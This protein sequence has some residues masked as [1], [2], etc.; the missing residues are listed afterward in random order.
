MVKRLW[1]GSLP[2]AALTVAVM[3]FDKITTDFSFLK[4]AVGSAVL[5]TAVGLLI[6][7]LLQGVGRERCLQHEEKFKHWQGP[8]TVASSVLLGVLV[9]L[10]SV[11]VG[12]LGV[13]MLTYLYPLRLNPSRMIASD[14]VHAIPLA[15]F[16]GIGHLLVGHVDF[17]LLAWLLFGS[18][19]DVW[20]GAKLSS[21][22]PPRMLRF[23]LATV[24]TAV[25]NKVIEHLRRIWRHTS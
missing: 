6:R 22:L 24:L 15:L 16:A 21:R 25:S 18:I 2:A 11:G 9:T 10:T 13:V 5:I 20:I 14:I 8:L 1:F 17:E 23:A 12:A 3:K 19:P 7:P 4:V